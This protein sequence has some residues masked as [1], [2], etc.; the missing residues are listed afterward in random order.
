MPF[1]ARGDERQEME[2]EDEVQVQYA[3]KVRCYNYKN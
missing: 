3:Y 2:S 1:V